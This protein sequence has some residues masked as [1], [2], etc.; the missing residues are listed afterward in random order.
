MPSAAKKKLKRDKQQA[1]DIISLLGAIAFP[2]LQRYR[3]S[4]PSRYKPPFLP[5]ISKTAHLTIALCKPASVTVIGSHA[6]GLNIADDSPVDV[7]VAIPTAYFH[8]KDYVNYRYHAKCTFFLAHISM[9]LESQ[10]AILW[11]QMEGHLPAIRVEYKGRT[12]RII[13]GISEDIFNVALRLAP[14]RNFFGRFRARKASIPRPS[15]T[16]HWR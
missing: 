14:S 1:D 9:Q 11:Q 16:P 13:C 10:T 15:T 6:C 2:S 5:P 12:Y 3:T 7:F 4:R 8:H